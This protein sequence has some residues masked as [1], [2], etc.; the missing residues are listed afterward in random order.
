[1]AKIYV[2]TRYTLYTLIDGVPTS[3]VD[4]V[5]AGEHLLESN[6]ELHLS[7]SYKNTSYC[8][9]ARVTSTGELIHSIEQAIEQGICND[10]MLCGADVII[11]DVIVC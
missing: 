1:M 9:V 5:Q 8:D 2:T 6:W 4:V 3:L 10:D 7:F 11:Y